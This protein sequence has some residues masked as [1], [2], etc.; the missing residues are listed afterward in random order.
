MPVQLFLPFLSI[1]PLFIF[2]APSHR[3]PSPPILLFVSF[4]FP[5]CSLTHSVLWRCCLG[6]RKGIRPVKTLSGGVLAWLSVWSKVQ[7]CIW[8]GWC[9]CNCNVVG[10]GTGH[11]PLYRIHAAITNPRRRQMCVSCVS[12]IQIGFTFLVPAHLDSS[13]KRAVQCVYVFPSVLSFPCCRF[14]SGLVLLKCSTCNTH[15]PV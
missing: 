14:C 5:L 1:F 15:T 10:A 3:L 12:K 9:H 2:P 4:P 6:G 13:W 11:L 7:T 8:P